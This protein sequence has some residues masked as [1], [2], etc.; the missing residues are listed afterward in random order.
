VISRLVSYIANLK[1]FL[2]NLFVIKKIPRN[3]VVE[4]LSLCFIENKILQFSNMKLYKN[5]KV[6]NR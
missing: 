3:C 1:S 4:F 6:Q 5:V 2:C